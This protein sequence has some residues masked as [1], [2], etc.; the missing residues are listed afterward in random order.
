M[1]IPLFSI[2]SPVYLDCNNM[3]IG[4]LKKKHKT[5]NK[6]KKGVPHLTGSSVRARNQMYLF[7]YCILGV[8]HHIRHTDVLDKD[9]LIYG[10]S[11]CLGCCR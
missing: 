3:V 10:W 8:K 9:L 4:N 6:T 7:H 2:V 11:P 5:K 1:S